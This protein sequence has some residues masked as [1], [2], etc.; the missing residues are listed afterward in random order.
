LPDEVWLEILS[1]LSEREL[2]TLCTV[3]WGFNSL[4][5]DPTLWRLESG[6]KFTTYFQSTSVP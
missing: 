1:Y 5:L 6:R 4:A 2:C 3:S